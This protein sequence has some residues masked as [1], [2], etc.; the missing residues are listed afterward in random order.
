MTA[1]A[2]N[3]E[4]ELLRLCGLW[5]DGGL[6]ET[7]LQRLSELLNAD[8]SARA[9]YQSYMDAHARLL[10]HFEPVPVVDGPTEE[11]AG[12]VVERQRPPRR[13]SWWSVAAAIAVSLAIGL[14][15]SQSAVNL[16]LVGAPTAGR[17]TAITDT[18]A[19]HLADEIEGLTSSEI[20]R[21]ALLVSQRESMAI[22]PVFGQPPPH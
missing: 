2:P 11:P 19:E 14:N 16:E 3:D 13:P 4:N 7:D 6:G 8:P 15:V 22:V 5:V 12:C 18:E 20:K 21:I 9:F 1:A 17:I 10:L